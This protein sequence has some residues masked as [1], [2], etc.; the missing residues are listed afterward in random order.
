MLV[1]IQVFTADFKQLLEVINPTSG[2]RWA[3]IL[4]YRLDGAHNLTQKCVYCFA[5]EQNFLNCWLIRFCFNTTVFSSYKGHRGEDSCRP[6]P[7]GGLPR[8]WSGSRAGR[9]QLR[10]WWLWDTWRSLGGVRSSN[11]L[12]LAFASG[13]E[14]TEKQ[15]G[16]WEVVLHLHSRPLPWCQPVNVVADQKATLLNFAQGF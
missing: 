14:T 3:G 10:L 6:R 8:L 12:Q 13:H 2:K 9:P 5:F 7:I 1:L 16:L 4:P 11:T 15:H